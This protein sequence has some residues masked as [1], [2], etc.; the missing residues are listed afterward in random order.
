[1]VLARQVMFTEHLLEIVVELLNSE[2]T[3][4]FRRPLAAEIDERVI[5][6]T[7]KMHIT[8]EG[9]TK[10]LKH[11]LNANRPETS[12]PVFDVIELPKQRHTCGSG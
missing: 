2:V 6:T 3:S 8:C 5:L 12:L 1:M 9:Y 4:G 11:G 7:E 10:D